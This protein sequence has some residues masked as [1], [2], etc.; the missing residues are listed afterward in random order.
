MF[1]QLKD[2]ANCQQDDLKALCALA[3]PSVQGLDFSDNDFCSIGA[4]ALSSA[5]AALSPNM[6]KLKFSLKDFVAFNDEELALI[7]SDVP[8]SVNEIEWDFANLKSE[9]DEKIPSV[10]QAAAHRI[11]QSANLSNGALCARKNLAADQFFFSLSVEPSSLKRLEKVI[12]Y[13]THCNLS[14]NAYFFNTL[15]DVKR[16][17]CLLGDVESVDLSNNQ[18]AHLASTEEVAI[19]LLA[20]EIEVILDGDNSKEQQLKAFMKQHKNDFWRLSNYRGSPYASGTNDSGLGLENHNYFSFWDAENFLLPQ[21]EPWLP[22]QSLYDGDSISSLEVVPTH[23]HSEEES[24]S[25][26]E[27]PFVLGQARL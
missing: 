13:V 17:M 27:L 1:L 23:N 6:T 19:L 5:M 9:L 11:A 16:M 26:D 2:L 21:S 7:F 22:K 12:P 10:L 24:D 20:A 18:L 25:C 4:A 14:S 3:L 15:D 8:V